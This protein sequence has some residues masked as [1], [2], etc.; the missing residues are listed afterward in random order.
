M[1]VIVSIAN[2]RMPYEV[3]DMNAT[4]ATIG[5]F[6]SVNL[7][8]AAIKGFVQD[9]IQYCRNSD[10]AVVST[11][12]GEVVYDFQADNSDSFTAENLRKEI[13]RLLH[14]EIEAAMTGIIGTPSQCVLSHIAD[15]SNILAVR[16]HLSA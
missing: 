8:K 7:A 1:K 12:T 14:G 6:D 2:N 15:L 10:Y 9:D 4:G 13:V 5:A 16:L 3:C 11:T